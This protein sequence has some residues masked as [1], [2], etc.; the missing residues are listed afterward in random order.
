MLIVFFLL[1]LCVKHHLKTGIIKENNHRDI[2]KGVCVN[3]TLK[4]GIIYI[5]NGHKDLLRHGAAVDLSM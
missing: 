3:K 1:L 5:M 2:S 4:S